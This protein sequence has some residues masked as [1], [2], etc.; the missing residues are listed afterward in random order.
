[1]EDILHL[2]RKILEIPG[3]YSNFQNAL[4]EFTRL[5]ASLGISCRQQESGKMSERQ[6]EDPRY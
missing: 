6:Y 4:G 3:I 5:Q 2:C 1:M